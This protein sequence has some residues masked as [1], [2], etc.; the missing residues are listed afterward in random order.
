MALDRRIGI[1]HPNIW[2][3]ISTLQS[4]SKNFKTKVLMAESSQKVVKKTKKYKNFETQLNELRRKYLD[5]E[6]TVNQF[7]DIMK[8]ID[9]S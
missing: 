7:I 4:Q 5:H 8:F 1:A 6:L 2:K 9:F 3:F